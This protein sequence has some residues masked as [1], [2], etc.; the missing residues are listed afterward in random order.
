MPIGGVPMG[1]MRR[2]QIWP[3]GRSAVAASV[4]LTKGEFGVGT[5][6]LDTGN[7]FLR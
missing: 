7:I 1:D 4:I 3:A 6:L 5:L 2:T